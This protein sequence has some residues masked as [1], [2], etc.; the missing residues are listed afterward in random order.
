MSSRFPRRVRPSLGLRSSSAR[1]HGAAL[2]VALLMLTVVLMLAVSAANIALQGEKAARND[3]DRQIALQAAEAALLDAELDI[4][5]SPSGETVRSDL[6]GSEQMERVP[7]GCSPGASR[8]FLGICT[9]DDR[10]PPAWQTV[11]FTDASEDAGSV[12]Y[13]F[14]TGRAFQIGQGSLPARL[15]RY[16]I[17]LSVHRNPD[18]SA[19]KPGAE[20]VY[21]ITAVG[22]GTRE[23]TQVAL[24]TLYR[25]KGRSKPETNAP[26][27]RFSWREIHNWEELRSGSQK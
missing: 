1:Q 20:D 8:Q 5:G 12:P 16:I 24:Q 22:F 25:K 3:R 6:F 19:V 13:G 11:D 15:P 10:M 23:T 18:N 9:T 7:K 4:E 21:R 17:E 2:I 26:V 14:F 27:G